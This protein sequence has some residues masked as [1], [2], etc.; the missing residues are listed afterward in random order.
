[1]E[2]T[3]QPLSHLQ[4]LTTDTLHKRVRINVTQ[5]LE[6]LETYLDVLLASIHIA[7]VAT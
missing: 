6:R 1:M 3:L 4:F 2:F 7:T 5:I